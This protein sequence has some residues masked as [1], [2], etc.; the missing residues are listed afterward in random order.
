MPG[1][2]LDTRYFATARHDVLAHIPGAPA[3]VLDIG[4]GYGSTTEALKAR[5][6]AGF[7]IGVEIDPVAA[8]EAEKHFD[9]VYC[10]AVEQAPFEEKIAPGTLDCVLCLDVLEHLVDPWAV[11]KRVSPLLAPGGRL[12]ISVP[13]IRNWKFIW[14]LLTRG[15]FHYTQSGLLDRTHLRFFVRE[16]AMELAAAGGLS[17]VD[18]VDARAYKPYEARAILNALTLGATRGL[19]AK[20]WIVIAEKR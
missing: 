2:T 8:G 19:I 1:H 9:H 18:A 5:G 17:V 6:G 11:V 12:Y 3:R 10:A 13:N 4:C 15:D 7:A 14:R 20:Q 16:T